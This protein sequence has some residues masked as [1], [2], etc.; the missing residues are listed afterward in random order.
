MKHDGAT[1]LA[2][3]AGQRDAL[4]ELVGVGYGLPSP[5]G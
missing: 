1:R 2:G 3:H 4:F 5:S